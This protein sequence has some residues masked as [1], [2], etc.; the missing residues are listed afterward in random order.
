MSEERLRE[1]V[2]WL[3]QRLP[4]SWCSALGSYIV[5]QNVKANRPGIIAGAKRNLARHFPAA[6][7]AEIEAMVWQFLEGVGR[8]HG[9]YGNMKQMIRQNRLEPVGLE[10]FRAAAEA[11]PMLVMGL[12]TGNWETFG[13]MLQAAKIPLTSFYAP[14]AD[15]LDRRVAEETRAQFGVDLL[16][17]DASGVRQAMRLLKQKRVVMIFPDEARNGVVMGPLFGRKPHLHGNLAIATRLARHTGA[18]IAILHS[19]R[20]APC[21]FKL[22]FGEAFTMPERENTDLL[23]DVAF[24]NSKVE[25][26]IRANLPRWYFL[27]DRI[28]EL[29]AS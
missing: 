12:H 20:T 27:D 5:R 4:I 9:E 17:P 15:A 13:P 21:R 8:V 6:N 2:Y 18:K 10:A 29:P 22:N 16:S 14:P 25:P 19:E 28:E 26:I 11:G 1:A 3:M 7:E 24:L 23:T